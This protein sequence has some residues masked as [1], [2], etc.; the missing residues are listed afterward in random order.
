V[1]YGKTFLLPNREDEACPSKRGEKV[2]RETHLCQRAS[3][4][5]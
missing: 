4:G 2:R 5:P 3:G 1:G